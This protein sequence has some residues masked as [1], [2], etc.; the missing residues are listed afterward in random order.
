MERVHVVGAL[1]GGLGDVN[2]PV[3]SRAKPWY[4]SWG[5]KSPEAKAKFEIIVQLLTFSCRK[6]S[7]VMSI[8]AELGQYSL[9]TQFKKKSEDSMGELE[10]P[11][12]VRR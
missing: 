7:I 1:P 4:G 2:P 8:G 11:I 6:F 3:G 5:T 9:Q 10:R 12:W